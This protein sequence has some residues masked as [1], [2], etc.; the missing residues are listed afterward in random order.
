MWGGLG[1][2]GKFGDVR[3]FWG[4]RGH[5]GTWE[6]LGTVS[7]LRPLQPFGDKGPIWGW[8]W[9]VGAEGC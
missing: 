1:T 3:G 8:G 6:H 9:R 4:Q 5:V 2:G 7:R